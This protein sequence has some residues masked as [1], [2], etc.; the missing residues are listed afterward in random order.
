MTFNNNLPAVLQRRKRDAGIAATVTAIALG[1]TAVAATATAAISL[2][3][4]VQTA[5]ASNTK[6]KSTTKVSDTQLQVNQLL[7]VGLLNLHHQVAITQDEVNSLGIQL[8]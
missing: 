1:L 5:A 6:S 7:Q 8:K 3:N 4:S 2:Q